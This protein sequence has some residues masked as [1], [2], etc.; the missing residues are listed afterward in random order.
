MLAINQNKSK[1]PQPRVPTFDGNPVEYCTFARAFESLIESRTSS[2]TERLYYLEQ[3]T[4]GD[5]KELVRSCHHLAPDEG[6]AEARGLIEKKFGDEFRIASAYESK[7]L[8]WPPV[9][10]EDGPALSRFSVYLASCKNA[11]KGSQYSSKFDQP[12]NIQKLILKLPYSM[13]ERWRRVVDDIME[14]QGRPVKFDDLVSFIDREARIATNPDFGQITENSRMDEARSGKGTVQK[15]LPKSREL[16]L[17]ARVNTDH[18]L[19]PEVDRSIN[20]DT[21]QHT[22][23]IAPISISCRFCGFNH[24]LEDCRSLRSRP[25]Q[26]RIQ[27]MA[28]KGLCFGCLSDKHVAKDCPQR[29]SCKFTNC[30][31]KHP[32]VLHT[33][34][35]ER[36]NGETS[37]GSADNVSGHATQVRNGMVSAGDTSCSVTGA[38]RPRTAMVIVPVKVKRKGSHTAIITYAFLDRGSSSTFCTESLMKQLGIDGLKTRI[39][40]TILERKGSLVDSFLVRDLVM[41]DLDESNFIAL[42]VLYTRTEIPVTK[43]DIPTQEDV[44]LWPHLGGVYFSNVSAE[45][46]LLISSDVPEALDPLEVRNSENGGPYASRTRIAGVPS[47][48]STGNK[49]LC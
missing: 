33:Q 38:G 24:A 21:S 18:G 32:T 47:S 49:L 9:K 25:Y 39:S 1:L 41:S 6:Y 36:S 5:V 10:S 2:G 48:G 27:F 3:Y 37:T 7:A 16:S 14:L 17:A 44:D 22:P 13:R 20:I 30:P 31:K 26:E 28:S 15:S 42:P 8:N 46:D 45:I 19:N 34:P 40:L 35:R 11:M 29:K 43:D 4:A 23:S 12:D